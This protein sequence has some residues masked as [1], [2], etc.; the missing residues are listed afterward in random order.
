M[1]SIH[2]QPAIPLQPETCHFSSLIETGPFAFHQIDGEGR[3][4]Y[5]NEVE[6][7]LLGYSRDEMVGRPIWEFVA[8]EDRQSSHKA[9]MAKLAGAAEFRPIRRVYLRKNGSS[10]IFEIHERPLL[11]QHG[12]LTGIATF[13]LDVTE[14]EMARRNTL[15]SEVWFRTTFEAIPEAIIAVDAIGTVKHLNQMA[16]ELTGFPVGDAQGRDYLDVFPVRLIHGQTE[17]CPPDMLLRQALLGPL[18]KPC[19]LEPLRRDRVLLD[20]E[21]R[22]ITVNEGDV[23]GVVFISREAQS[24][25]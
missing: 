15:E 1:S 20:V 12:V 7:K 25:L 14:S 5:V 21:A 8:P 4:V 17:A 2:P 16:A 10:V 9:V 3:V 13:M 6:S 23:L 19:Y 22:P 18:R 24:S 11:N